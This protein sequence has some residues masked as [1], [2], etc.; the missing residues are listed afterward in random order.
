MDNSVI[1]YDADRVRR[2]RIALAVVAGL[3][4]VTGGIALLVATQADDAGRYA[5]VLGVVAVASVLCAVIS[6]RLLGTPTDTAKR[7]VIITGALSVLFALATF[8]VAVGL[9]YVVLGLVLIFL[10][11]IGDEDPG[12]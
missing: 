6:W 12:T 10:A 3:G 4:V 2:L 8:Q 7:A 1:V 11:V 9:L 5:V